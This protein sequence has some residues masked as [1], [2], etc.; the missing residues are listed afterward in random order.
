MAASS[1]DAKMFQFGL[2]TADL[3]TGELLKNGRRVRLSGQPFQILSHLLVRA[4]DLVTREELRESLWPNDTFVDFDHSLNSS[5]N[6]LREALDDSADSPRFIETLPRRGYRFIYPINGA[7][8]IGTPVEAPQAVT[9]WRR[10]WV[11]GSLMLVAGGAVLAAVLASNIGGLRDRAFGVQPGPIHSIAVLP[12]KNSTSDP[13]LDSFA[14][15]LTDAI[16]T[17]LAPV[18]SLRVISV[19]SAMSYKAQRKKLPEIARELQVDAVVEGSVM[20]TAGATQVTVQ[21]VHAPSD[22]HL[23]ANRYQADVN[24]PTLPARLAR[25]IIVATKAR[26]SEQEA[27]RL[28]REQAVSPEAYT[29]YRKAREIWW[30]KI[31]E[32]G[33]WRSI[34]YYKQAI[35]KDPKFADAY[36]GMARSYMFLH[37]LYPTKEVET[38]LRAAAAK[39]L[40]LDPSLS[41][42]HAVLGTMQIGKDWT[43]AEKEFRLALELNPNDALAHV[44]YAW[45]LNR[46]QRPEEALGEILRAEQLD[47]LSPYVSAN[48]ILRYNLLRRFED[49]VKQGQKALELNRDFWLTYE[50]LGGT[51]WQMGRHD[52]AIRLWEKE[53]TLPGVYE[54]WP[55][56]RLVRTYLEVGRK[57]EALKALARLEEVAKHRYVEPDRLALALAAV[58]RKDEAIRILQKA[59]AGEDPMVLGIFR[60]QLEKYL[61][62]DP[63]FQQMRRRAG[64]PLSPQRKAN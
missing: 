45:F 19:T 26:F 61:G 11:M 12:F 62:D 3:R 49:A 18:K 57:N 15:A 51:Y 42:P 2:F 22:T 17:D 13:A 10:R 53:L 43:A 1:P 41:E 47:P 30:S 32:E 50:N 37:Q 5:I 21:L 48:V 52:E 56:S 46:R 58:G 25:D 9:W 23:W 4:G 24:D 7:A 36:A 20:R 54:A 6:K 28:A 31:S 63:R 44:W 64:I 39:A 34:E 38:E 40:E 16:T 8:T 27:T 59:P 33:Y 35:T 14:D 29:A 55:L 60:N